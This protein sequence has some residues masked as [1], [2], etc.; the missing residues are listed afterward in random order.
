MSQSRRREAERI[1]KAIGEGVAHSSMA[2][3]VGSPCGIVTGLPALALANRQAA[4]SGSTTT[5]FGAI[6]PSRWLA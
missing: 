6:G 5:I 2:M 1:S 3:T 4:R